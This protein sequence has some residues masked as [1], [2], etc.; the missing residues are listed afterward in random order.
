VE[1]GVRL[2][3]PLRCVRCSTSPAWPVV[4]GYE[5]EQEAEG[6]LR[7]A[8]SF[9]ATSMTAEL[10]VVPAVSLEQ[11]REQNCLGLS[12]LQRQARSANQPIATCCRYPSVIPHRPR[13][14]NQANPLPSTQVA[15]QSHRRLHR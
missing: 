14:A 5:P 7:S 8:W 12:P 15:G 13:P 10:A 1:R 11:G 3:A 6:G 4:R 9:P 2:V